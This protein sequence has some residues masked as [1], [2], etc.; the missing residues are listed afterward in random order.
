MLGGVRRT[1]L[2]PLKCELF[3][4]LNLGNCVYYFT[5]HSFGYSFIYNQG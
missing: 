4:K 5:Q 3:K 2:C 1:I